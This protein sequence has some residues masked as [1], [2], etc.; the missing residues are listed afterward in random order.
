MRDA[1]SALTLLVFMTAIL[2]SLSCGSDES[3]GP[4]NGFVASEQFYHGFGRGEHVLVSVLGVSGEVKITG[5][6]GSDSIVVAGVKRVT[7]DNAEDAEEHLD[8]LQVTVTNVAGEVRAVTSQPGDSNGR[9]YEV[10]YDVSIPPDLPVDVSHVN[11]NVIISSVTRP[12]A[13]ENVNGTVALD[14]INASVSAAVTNGR[15]EGDITLPLEGRIDLYVVNGSIA[16]DIPG[17]TSAEF[18]AEVTNGSVAIY[19]LVLFN[20][21]ATAVSERGILGSGQGEIELVV[22]NGTIEV[23]GF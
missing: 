5:V 1:A 9:Q 23:N 2:L 22:V 12:V 17:D 15:I 10:E 11:G 18:M 21:V 7:S 4:G 3:T 14:A 19:G 20:R 16:L 8:S 6:A 13:A